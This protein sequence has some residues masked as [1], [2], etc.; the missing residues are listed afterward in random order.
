MRWRFYCFL[1][2]V[3]G[4][5]CASAGLM[6]SFSAIRRGQVLEAFEYH[7][8]GPPLFFFLV[9]QIPYRIWA[10]LAHPRPVPSILRWIH[11]VTASVVIVT[12]I[13]D[14]L[15]LMGGRVL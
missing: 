15:F 12:M 5:K 2:D 14:W 11:G 9:L 10:L 4:V 7:P 3:F 8:V 13:F 6:R 1:D